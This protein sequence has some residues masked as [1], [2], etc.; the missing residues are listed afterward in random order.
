[1]D[2]ITHIGANGMPIPIDPPMPEEVLSEDFDYS[3]YI[4]K[5]IQPLSDEEID[6]LLYSKNEPLEPPKYEK[7][8]IFNNYINKIKTIQMIYEDDLKTGLVSIDYNK[9]MK[10][11]A[12]NYFNFLQR[13][14]KYRLKHKKNIKR[15]SIKRKNKFFPSRTITRRKSPIE[16]DSDKRIQAFLNKEIPLGKLYYYDLKRTLKSEIY[17]RHRRN[18]ENY[19]RH[20]LANLIT[21]DGIYSKPIEELNFRRK[22]K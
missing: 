11:I 10:E 5:E 6:E 1:M 14:I 18:L 12:Q 19:R 16:A 20:F 4:E 15:L 22:H 3:K 8:T 7:S 9:A 2:E 17:I 21:T 13:Q